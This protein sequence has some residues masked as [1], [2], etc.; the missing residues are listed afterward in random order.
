MSQVLPP[1]PVCRTN[2]HINAHGRDEFFCGKCKGLFDSAPD[3][4]G[5]YSDR[6]PAWRITRSE[7]RRGGGSQRN[8]N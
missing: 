3:E 5:S 8:R 6:D 2:R 7:E 1:C 4:G